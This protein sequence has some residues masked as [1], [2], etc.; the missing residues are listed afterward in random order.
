MAKQKGC[1]AVQ[2]IKLLRLYSI[3]SGK[4]TD[5]SKASKQTSLGLKIISCRKTLKSNCFHRLSI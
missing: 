4:L 1:T 3:T 2:K 5:F